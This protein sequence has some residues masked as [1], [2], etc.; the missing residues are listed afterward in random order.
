MAVNS[1]EQSQR[2]Q[3]LAAARSRID[4][5]CSRSEDAMRI[6]EDAYCRGDLDLFD[7]IQWARG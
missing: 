6:A 7:Y 1:E 4:S 2:R 3:A 5:E